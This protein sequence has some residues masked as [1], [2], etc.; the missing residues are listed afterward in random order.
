[1]M[2][3][4]DVLIIV[5]IGAVVVFAAVRIVKNKKR[6]KSSCGCDCANCSGCAAMRQGKDAGEGIEKA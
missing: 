3:F 4:W 2:N 6:G 5:L 1:M